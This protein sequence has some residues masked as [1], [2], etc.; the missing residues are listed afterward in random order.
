MKADQKEAEDHLD[1]LLA[2]DEG[3]TAW[4]LGFLE[5]CNAKREVFFAKWERNKIFQI[6]KE[7]CK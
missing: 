2:L 3:L 6:Y 1:D 7:R 4:E 5:R